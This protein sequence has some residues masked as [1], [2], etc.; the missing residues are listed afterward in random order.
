MLR[1]M[2]TRSAGAALALLLALAVAACSPQA[3]EFTIGECV[4]LPDGQEITDYETVDCAEP[5]DGEVY[6]LPQHPDGEDAPFPGQEAL[7]EFSAERCEAEFEEYVGTSFEESAFFF[8]SL[9]PGQEAWE[10]AGDR[11][12]VCL[13]VGAPAGDGFEQLTGSKRDSGE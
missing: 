2:S 6:A 4:N 5:H 1:R 7:D 10:G 8:T 12:V 13:L 11:E 3:L 9:S